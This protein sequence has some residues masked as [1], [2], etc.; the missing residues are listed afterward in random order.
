MRLFRSRSRVDVAGLPKEVAARLVQLVDDVAAA[1]HDLRARRA[2]ADCCKS[3][4]RLEEAIAH[5]Q[6]L[7]GAYAAQ[8]LLFRAIA[9][10]KT[11]LEI[12]PGHTETE[13][14]LAQLY[15]RHDVQSDHALT[16]ELPIAM[17]AALVLDDDDVLESSA[18]ANDSDD[19]EAPPLPDLIDDLEPVAADA[20][21][22]DAD[23]ESDNDDD[24]E[25]VDGDVLAAL[26]VKTE[27]SVALSRPQAVPLFSGLS[28][29]RFTEL[30]QALRCWQADAGAVIVAEGEPGDSVFVI[31]RGAVAIQRT[32]DDGSVIELAQMGDGDFFGEIAIMAQRPRAA[33]VVALRTT[34]LLEIDRTTLAALVERDPHVKDTLEGFCTRRLIENTMK[35]SPLFT[36]LDDTSLLRTIGR[37]E[38][39]VVDDGATLVHQGEGTPG[40]HILLQGTIDVVAST[41]VDGLTSTV[42]LKRLGPGDVFGE[43]GLLRRQP[44]TASCVAVGPARLAVL[45]ADTFFALQDEHPGLRVRLQA[46]V[47]ARAAFNARFL[48]A[49]DTSGAR[50]GTV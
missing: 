24:E 21:D 27:G 35:T 44:A 45:G 3:I 25:I 19:D 4:G 29:S 20:I 22:A 18:V 15:A 11:I 47:D 33:S 10:C 50:A 30:V 39:V 6:A 42:R 38:S 26:T 1:P 2:L 41:T 31:A 40:L 36:G 14:A 9:V 48:P 8:G 17:G 13:L 5:Y 23:I 32:A 7:A 16:V 43:M 46:I 34:E 49:S 28:S 37:F 12:D